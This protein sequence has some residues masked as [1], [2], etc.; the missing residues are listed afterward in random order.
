M[1]E[2]TLIDYRIRLRGWPMR[3]RTLIRDWKPPC[4]FTDEQLRGPYRRW[5]HRHTFEE[6]DGGTLARDHVRYAL[7]FSP[8]GELAHPFVRAELNRIF[9]FRQAALERIFPGAAKTSEAH[10]GA[11]PLTGEPTRPRG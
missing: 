11:R 3:W 6:V 10:S 1:R 2:G 5:I 9:S 4:E 7:P 8:L